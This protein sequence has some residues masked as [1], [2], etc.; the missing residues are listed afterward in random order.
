MARGVP[1]RAGGL[2]S[3]NSGSPQPRLI[4]P[5]GATRPPGPGLT[6]GPAPLSQEQIVLASGAVF[7][8]QG[9]VGTPAASLTI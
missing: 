3:G 5:A 1:A 4:V 2:D 8:Y 6:P 9:W 7:P